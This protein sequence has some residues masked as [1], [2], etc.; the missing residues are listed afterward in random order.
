M[1][2]QKELNRSANLKVILKMK[3]IVCIVLLGILH[4]LK[5]HCF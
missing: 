1:E 4:I 3:Y 5:V 2:K